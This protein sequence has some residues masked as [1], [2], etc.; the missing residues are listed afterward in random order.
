[1]QLTKDNEKVNQESTSL[2]STK[3]QVLYFTENIHENKNDQFIDDQSQQVPSNN[4]PDG[5]K[6]QNIIPQNVTDVNDIDILESKLKDGS[7]INS[8]SHDQGNI[9]ENFSR[10][11][12]K[13]EFTFENEQLP[14]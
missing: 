11:N 1:M 10:P 12:I 7:V 14:D 2:D 6:E 9:E 13:S 8:Q 3:I 5:C 4:D